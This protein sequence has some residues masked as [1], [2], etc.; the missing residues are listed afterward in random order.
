MSRRLVSALYEDFY[1]FDE[2]GLFDKFAAVKY[3]S[4]LSKEDVLVVWGGGDIPPQYYNKGR[5]S[6]SW[7]SV[8]PGY[9]DAAEWALVQRAMELGIPMIGVCR[10]GQMMCAAAG[11]YLI[12]HVTG[13]GGNHLV[14]TKEGDEFYTNS[15][16]HQ[17]MVPGNAKH[18]LLAHIPSPLSKE[19]WD[20]NTVLDEVD[21]ER[22]YIYFNDIKAHAIQWHP[23]GLGIQTAANKYLHSKLKETFSD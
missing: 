19:Y 5:S 1:P 12:Q 15:I 13:H 6:K 21:V 9:R 14:K 7:A 16:H 8:E 17:M 4:E 18:E 22:E 11:G 10:G 23:E 20:E 3:P 2:M